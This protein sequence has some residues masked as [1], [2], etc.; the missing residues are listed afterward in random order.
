RALETRQLMQEKRRLEEAIKSHA[1]QLEDL[2]EERT[3]ELAEA[4]N[5]LNLVLDSS[6]EYGIV[7]SAEGRF[8]L[9]NRGAELIFRCSQQDVLGRSVRDLFVEWGGD[10]VAFGDWAREASRSGH[11]RAEGNLY[12]ADGTPFFGVVTTTAIRR[13]DGQVI[14]HLGIIKDQTARRQSDEALKQIQEKLATTER[15]AALGRVA[16]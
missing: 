12:R 1:E 3:G 6:T 7:A 11:H 10:P 5:F 9:F 13:P 16:A 14:G 15:I 2:V 8:N 4:H